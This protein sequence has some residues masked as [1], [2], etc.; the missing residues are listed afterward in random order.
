MA[1]L[2]TIEIHSLKDPSKTW[3]I[4]ACDFDPALHTKWGNHVE[5][6]RP[7]ADHSTQDFVEKDGSIVGV[8]IIDPDNRRARKT[9]PIDDYDIDKHELWSSHPRFR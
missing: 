5:R 7:T 6:A 2:P 9:I 3:V 4:N 1:S 8:N